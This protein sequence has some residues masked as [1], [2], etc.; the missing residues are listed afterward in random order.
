MERVIFAENAVPKKILI[1]YA[2]APY[3]KAQALLCKTAK[4]A[5][6]TEWI[7]YG[8]EDVD[9]GFR[10]AHSDIFSFERGDGLWLWKPY[11]ILKTLN[12]V[13]DGNIVFYCDS[14]ACFFGV[15]PLY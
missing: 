13:K 15:P 8:P 9:E 10:N 14:G 1:S 12:A 7:A 4:K 3:Q 6:F 5:G 2:N 11:L